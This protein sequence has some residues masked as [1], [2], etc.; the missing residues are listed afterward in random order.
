MRKSV[1]SVIAKIKARQILDSRGIPTVEVNLFTNKGMYEAVELHDGGKGVYLGNSVTRVV[2]NI[3]VKI[4]KALIGMDPVSSWSCIIKQHERHK[5]M[6]IRLRRISRLM[7]QLKDGSIETDTA[8]YKKHPS[9][10]GE[11]SKRSKK[12][13][14][15]T[16]QSKSKA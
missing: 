2:R 3:N 13:H 14:F 5:H 6:P 12:L 1:A 8:E 11:F 10:V 16:H 15:K 4:S 9:S 7:D